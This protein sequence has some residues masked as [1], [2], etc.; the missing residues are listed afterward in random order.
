MKGCFFCKPGGRL[1][2]VFGEGRD[3][4]IRRRITVCPDV[5][6]TGNLAQNRE[7]LRETEVAFATWGMPVFTEEEIAEYFPRLRV[8]FYAAGS[9]QHFARPF[10][11][12]GVRILSAWKTMAIP[13]AE[14]TVAQIVLANKGALTTLGLYRE[15]GYKTAQD[16]A[17]YRTPGTY[18]TKVGILGAG[19]IGT[20]VIE[21]LKSYSVELLV[22]DP[23]LSPERA[24]ALG[25]R[26][27]SLEEIFSECQ[28]VSNH[29]ANKPETVGMLNY[30][31][32]S[33]MGDCTAFINTGRGAQ[34]VEEDLIRALTEN[35]TRCAVLDVTY[36][37]PAEAGGKLLT[38]PNVFLFP[39]IAGAARSEV[40]MM[41]DLMIRE[42]DKYLSGEPLGDCEVTL[43]ML[44]RMA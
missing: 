9:V 21:M 19:A 30:S 5:I 28:T 10:L 34:V 27:A 14:F 13:V 17:Y 2:Y 22:Y 1:G 26:T 33:R 4:E 40:L 7:F 8:L 41:S 3:G 24:D 32:F 44:A 18:R 6:H 39:H 35:P 20:R 31:H 16:H 36:P 23:F 29:I 42:L 43:P 12:R 15:Q 38:M 25:V 37:E 11:A